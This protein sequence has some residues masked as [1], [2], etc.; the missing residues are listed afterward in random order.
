MWGGSRSSEPLNYGSST[1]CVNDNINTDN[2]SDDPSSSSSN[3][4]SNSTPYN[5][6][7]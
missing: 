5:Y 4:L 3:S 1:T 6:R 2:F 7:H